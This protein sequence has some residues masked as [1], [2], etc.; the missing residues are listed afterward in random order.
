MIKGRTQC[1]AVCIQIFKNT[2]EVTMQVKLAIGKAI[3]YKL[4][5]YE[6]ICLC[7]VSTLFGMICCLTSNCSKSSTT[8]LRCIY[9]TFY[10]CAVVCHFL[11]CQYSSQCNEW[12]NETHWSGISFLSHET[13]RNVW[14]ADND[15]SIPVIDT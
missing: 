15:M 2:W 13:L 11:M 3:L 4:P 7:W 5:N 8:W 9:I 6:Y 1:Y 14:S 12:Y 10:L